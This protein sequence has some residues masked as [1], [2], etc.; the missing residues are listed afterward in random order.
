MATPGGVACVC[1]AGGC[2][3]TYGRGSGAAARRAAVA[4]W[5]AV[6]AAPGD[7]ATDPAGRPPVRARS[8]TGPRAHRDPGEL[9]RVL[10]LPY[11][12]PAAVPAAVDARAAARKASEVQLL[13]REVAFVPW[14]EVLSLLNF[15]RLAGHTPTDREP[16]Q[17]RR[18]GGVVRDRWVIAGSVL[19]LTGRQPGRGTRGGA[20]ATV[21][22]RIFDLRTGRYVDHLGATGRAV[23]AGAAGN[24]ARPTST[25]AQAVIRALTLAVERALEPFLAPYPVLHPPGRGSGPRGPG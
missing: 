24:G 10:V 23:V 15:A 13:R 1:R 4:L 8:R 18:L 11:H 7:A 22:V 2:R 14:E 19:S 9:T 17:L 5:F 25:E 12:V 3:Q 20:A 21:Q 6:A 16:D